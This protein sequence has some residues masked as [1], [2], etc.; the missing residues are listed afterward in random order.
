MRSLASLIDH[1][2]LKPDATHAQ[3]RR[4]CEE[5]RQFGFRSVCVNSLHVPVVADWLA[6]SAAAVCAVVGFPLGA[7]SP[8]MKAAEAA[9]AVAGG[10]SE[11][12]MVIDIGALK[13]G[14][15]D[16]V[17]E[18]IAAV[19]S[20]A[21]DATLKVIIETCLLTDDEKRIACRIAAM[22]GA[23]FVKTSTG[24]SSGGATTADVALMY[25]EVGPT[26][27]VKASGG[28]RTLEVAR[29]MLAAGATRIGTSAGV[30]LVTQTEPVSTGY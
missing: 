12:D 13:D 11:I 16:A 22:A 1:T 14:R 30:A 27:G 15:V 9:E 25:A 2:I 8:A 6:G 10:A 4:F 21:H 28:I 19:R 20:A 23:N 3:I 18:D 24:F 5:A 7:V 29:A 26:V 17:R